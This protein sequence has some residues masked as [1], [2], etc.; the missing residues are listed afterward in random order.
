MQA[1]DL[2]QAIH[3]NWPAAATPEGTLAIATFRFARLLETNAQTVLARHAL[4]F[5][6]FELLSALRASPPP[7]RLIPSDLCA[8]LLISS[9]GLTKVLKSLE[10]RALILRPIDAQD[11]R[12]RPIAL[13]DAGRRL[14][15]TA[16]GEVQAAD[17]ARI[18]AAELSKAEAEAL[19][20]LLLRAQLPFETAS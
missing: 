20:R 3:A 1:R 9:G 13:S 4:S 16:M 15:E 6:E 5:T 8:A 2:M 11:R 17:A 18:A 14:V 12:R 10:R 7:H 19:T